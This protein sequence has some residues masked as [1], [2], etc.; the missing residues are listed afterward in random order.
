MKI[1]LILICTLTS[2]ISFSQIDTIKIA[3]RI[4]TIK[5]LAE[6]Q[7]YWEEIRYRDQK[8]RGSKAIPSYDEENM[9]SVCMYFNKF[10]YPNTKKMG[11]ARGSMDMV[12]IHNISNEVG[13]H[14]FPIL[15]A[16][17]NTKELPE[18]NI[19]TYYLKGMYNLY[20]D[21]E[22]Y[23]ERPL[24]E[25]YKALN[26]NLSPTVDI[27]KLVS[28]INDFHE[29]KKLP[30]TIICKWMEGGG[31]DTIESNL[32]TYVFNNAA[33]KSEIYKLKDGRIFLHKYY[34][35]YSFDPKELVV[36]NKSASKFRYKNSL[37][38]TYLEI[39]K[40]GNL[41]YYDKNGVEYR[42]HKLIEN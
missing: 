26:L 9:V 5:T 17:L 39:T 1:F 6:H 36:I 25:I 29:F 23:G 7:K 32:N 40:S 16:G 3:K 33:I 27:A 21:D 38:K 12:W 2:L 31:K 37:T 15:L 13:R 35:D 19:R 10:G 24:D 18:D 28:L 41:V 14:T 34:N 20:Y 8:F 30:K 4:N 42:R 22:L 11:Y